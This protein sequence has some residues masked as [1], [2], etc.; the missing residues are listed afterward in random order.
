MQVGNKSDLLRARQ[1]PADEGET[2]AASL[3][4][5]SSS[6]SSSSSY[7]LM[8]NESGLNQSL[9]FYGFAFKMKLIF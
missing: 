8:W 9:K 7:Y 6:S 1:V 3:G 4:G 5:M 2:L